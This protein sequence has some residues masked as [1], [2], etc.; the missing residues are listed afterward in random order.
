MY[1]VPH[2]LNQKQKTQVNMHDILTHWNEKEGQNEHCHVN[3]NEMVLKEPCDWLDLE[4]NV[5]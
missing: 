2:E 5:W 1:L 3:I 4:I